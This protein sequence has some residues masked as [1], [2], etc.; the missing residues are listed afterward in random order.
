MLLGL[1]IGHGACDIVLHS[2][3]VSSRF[4]M[5]LLMNKMPPVKQI[6]F[7]TV[8]KHWVLQSEEITSQFFL[9]SYRP[10]GTV[11]SLCDITASLGQWSNAA[12]R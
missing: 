8:Q 3:S 11:A 7:E 9:S 6:R 4:V 2:P 5:E 10:D 1:C 12:K